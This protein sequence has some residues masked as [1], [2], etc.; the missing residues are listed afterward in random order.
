MTIIEK[1][2]T[3]NPIKWTAIENPV[4]VSQ[5]YLHSAGHWLLMDEV[6]R[7]LDQDTPEEF[8]YIFENSNDDE[9]LDTIID[10]L[11]VLN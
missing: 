10:V 3:Q 9:I 2:A 6:E 7:I 11:S 8:K 4:S 1:L 5:E